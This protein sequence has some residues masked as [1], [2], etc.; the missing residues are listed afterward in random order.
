M[1]EIKQTDKEYLL[2]I[3]PVEKDRARAIA[4]YRWN[5]NRRCWV[6]PKTARVYDALLAEFRDEM[7]DAGVP[8]PDVTVDAETLA[9]EHQRLTDENRALRQELDIAREQKNGNGNGHTNG[10]TKRRT[11][12]TDVSV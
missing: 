9:S 2:F 3:P 6:Y 12:Q 1:I 11:D 4:G 8:R 10:A 7:P 5:P